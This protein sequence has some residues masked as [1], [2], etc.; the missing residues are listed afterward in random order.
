MIRGEIVLD[1]IGYGIIGCGFIG[2]LHARV[3]HSL[4]NARVAAVCDKSEHVAQQLGKLYGCPSYTNY[5][6]M[7]QNSAVDAVTI[8]LPSGMHGDA[9]IASA[10]AKKHILCEKPIEINVERAKEMV[11]VAKQNGVEFGVILQ[12]RFDEPV[13]ALRKIINQGIM[14]NLLWGASRTLTYRNS[15]YFANPWRGTWA[16]DGG[17]ALINQ[18]IHYIDLLLSFFGKV[19]S[20]S[21]KCRT[22][23]HTQIETE[24]VGV[25]NLEFG[26]GKIGTVE[27]STVC[28]PGAY[29]E[30]CLFAEKGT[31][32]IR[33]DTL[34]FY[35]LS[36]GKHKDLDKLLD[37]KKAMG[38]GV[39]QQISED[40]HCRQFEDFT[41][42]I[43][44][45]RSP[46]VTG[47]EA[48]HSLEVIKA[49]YQSSKE[50]REI[51]L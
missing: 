37:T 1:Q 30:L 19:S 9:T 32:I 40:S 50:K 20:V 21:G 45:K 15:E 28:F 4:P 31:A 49:I 38:Q 35:E 33:N 5:E 16:Y 36:Q 13:I 26:N 22:L 42:A 46:L 12:R 10:L 39:S 44:E 43:I 11:N 23:L 6:E 8:A 51:Y 41:K 47:V 2:E 14:G 29:A 27:G 34:M 25:A 48:L 7:L 17:G 18:S 24:D 3:V